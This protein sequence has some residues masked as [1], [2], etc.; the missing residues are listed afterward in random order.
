MA[1]WI[2][3]LQLEQWIIHVFAGSLDI[4]VGIAMFF[5][6]GLASYFRMNILTMAFM[7]IIF[8]LMF[9]LWM[10]VYF[11]LIIGSIGGLLIGSWISKIV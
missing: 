2:P 10:P 11:M 1:T 4:F 5:I 6:F 8:L 3:P 7:F 9:S